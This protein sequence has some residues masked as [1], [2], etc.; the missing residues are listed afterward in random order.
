MFQNSPALLRTR[1]TRDLMVVIGKFRN[2]T[3]LR[4]KPR[5]QF[6]Y[7]A[8]I[9]TDNNVAI[10]C[11]IADISDSGAR[12]ALEQQSELPETF[13]LLLTA[14]GDVRRHCRLVWRNET[15][16]GVEFPPLHPQ[17]QRAAGSPGRT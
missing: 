6:Q 11:E 13:M 8:R 10:A 9:L 3:E 16:V 17:Q 15:H 14:E 7:A 5:R 2:R 12:L 4:K 1:L